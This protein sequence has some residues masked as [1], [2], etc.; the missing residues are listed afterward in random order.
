M[1]QL[2][3]NLPKKHKMVKP[4]YQPILKSQIP[5]VSLPLGAPSAD[6]D[7]ENTVVGKARIIAGELG[8]AK[9]AAKTFSP[10]QMWDVQLPH[11]G[12]EVDLPFPENHN[13]IVFVR[14]GS[15]DVLSGNSTEPKL[16]SSPLGA[17]DVALMRLDGSN[18]LRLRVK[19]PDT[20]IMILGGEPIN[21]PIAAQGPFVMNR[22]E[23]IRQ[24]ILDYQMGRMGK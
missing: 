19:E 24:A 13:C 6:N 2:W 17:Q 12:A 4:N 20:Q 8:D 5:E 1:C 9:G 7:G 21:E 10:V 11:A 22:P 3:V 18:T 15:V 23:E 16:K 14:R